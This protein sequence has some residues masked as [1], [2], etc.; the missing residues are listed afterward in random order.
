MDQTPQEPRGGRKYASLARALTSVVRR[1]GERPATLL[2]RVL[3]ALLV[4]ALA[5]GLAVG[6]GALTGHTGSAAP[7]HRSEA[8]ASPSAEARASD[9]TDADRSDTDSGPTRTGGAEPRGAEPAAEPAAIGPVRGGSA[10]VAGSSGGSAEDSSKPTGTPTSDTRAAQEDTPPDAGD[11]GSGTS[12]G[13][14]EPASRTAPQPKVLARSAVVNHGAGKCIDVTDE[15]RTGVQIELW[16]CEPVTPW[17]TWTFYSDGTVRSEGNCMTAVG[18]GDGAPI[19][20][21]ACTGGAGQRFTLNASHDL[22]NISA[23]RCVDVTD[24]RVG[25]NGAKLQLWSCSGADNQKWSLR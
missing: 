4:V 2:G 23:D 15:G 24:G 18:T 12:E 11:S 1:P 6:V 25:D 5:G 3:P 8:E 10:P 20:V 9:R 22:V 16:D 21:R 13:A 17:R 19:Q 7:A 14:D